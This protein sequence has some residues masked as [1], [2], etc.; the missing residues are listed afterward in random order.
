VRRRE[1]LSLLGSAPAA[2]PFT[3][4][5]QQGERMRRIGV[6]MLTSSDEPESQTYIAAFLQGLQE[7]GWAVGRNLRIDYRW[8]RNDR[9]RLNQHAAELI[10]LGPDVVLAGVGG[11]T[12]ALQRVSRTMPIVFAQN[13]DPVGAGAVLSLSRPGTN[14]T[15]FTQF[16]YTLSAK[17]LELLREIAPG[18]TRAAI[19][20]DADGFAGIGQWAVIQA[21]ASPLGIELTPIDPRDIHEVQLAVSSLQQARN[22]GLIVA[23][24]SAALRNR[25]QIIE[26]AARHKLPA[27]Y[28]YRHFVAAGGLVSYGVDLTSL[29]RRAAGYVDR[30]L[31]GEKPADLPVQAPTKYELVINLKTAKALGLDVPPTLLARADEVIE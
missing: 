4:L 16:E 26:L 9:A 27:V 23:V 3:A 21:A 13:I 15:G 8:S 11:T 7:A 6:L 1:F 5:A 28:A 17:W 19:V 14:A 30:I 24:S 20:R 29:Y 25:E 22:S 12:P 10:S 2:W 18:L 31:R